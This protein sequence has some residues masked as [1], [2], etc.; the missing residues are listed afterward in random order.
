MNHSGSDFR[1]LTA[2]P[3]QI[4]HYLIEPIEDEDGKSKFSVIFFSYFTKR[5][6]CISDQWSSIQ[7]YE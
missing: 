4:F 5:F 3:K 2:G 6:Q 7:R 1:E